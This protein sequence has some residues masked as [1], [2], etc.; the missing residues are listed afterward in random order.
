[1]DKQITVLC[2]RLNMH[3]I[4]KFFEYIYGPKYDGCLLI[5]G[6]VSEFTIHLRHKRETFT[7]K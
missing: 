4:F 2:H 6:I 7:N 5:E 1:M 3:S